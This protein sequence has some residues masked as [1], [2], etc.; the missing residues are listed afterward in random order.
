M[1]THT[2]P[3]TGRRKITPLQLRAEAAGA[4]A[5]TPTT[6]GRALAAFKRAEP[7]LGAPAQVVK[8]VD[9]LVGRTRP[10][11]WDGSAGLGPIAWPSDAELEDRLNVGPSQRKATIRAALDAGYVRLHRSPNGKRWGHRDKQGRITDAYGFDLAPLAERTSEFDRRSAEWEARRDEGRRL[12]REI[13]T[14]RNHVLSLVDL[15]LAQELPGE[16]WPAAAAKADALWHERGTQRDPLALVP[17]A[18]RLRA[19]DIHVG[20]QVAAALAVVEHGEYGEIDPMGP[21]YRPHLTTTTQLPIAKANTN[22]PAQPTEVGPERPIA[23]KER[24]GSAQPDQ[25][26]AKKSV[27]AELTRKSAT[28][29]GTTVGAPL[30][31]KDTMPSCVLRGFV[32][33]PRFILEIAPIFRDW[34]SS[35]WPSWEEL[36][37]VAYDVRGAIGISPHAWGQAWIT[38]GGDGAITALAAICARHAAGKVKS[39]GGLL[40]KMVELHQKGTLRLDRTLFGLA[41]KVGYGRRTPAERQCGSH[42]TSLL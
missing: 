29:N 30:P 18:A 15:A 10:Q 19:L 9:Y 41:E 34:T 28:G 26:A 5:F 1:D 31:Q 11:D 12:R 2:A 37:R 36:S 3:P 17:I 24:S 6:P 33:T 7:A 14:S 22:A 4:A 25:H 39:P 20:E 42:P 27:Q 35:A 21:E 23:H 32:V 40:R 16:D 38:L 8:L 13:T